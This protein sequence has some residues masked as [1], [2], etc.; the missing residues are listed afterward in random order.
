MVITSEIILAVI[1][2]SLSVVMPIYYY[3]QRK[4]NTK[5]DNKPTDNLEIKNYIDRINEIT[6]INCK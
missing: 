1:T 4:K 2:V 3:Y 5:Q 6:R